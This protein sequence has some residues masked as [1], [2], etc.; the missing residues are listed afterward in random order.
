[1]KPIYE[2]ILTSKGID[3]SYADYLVAQAAL[4][5]NWGKSQSGKNNLSGIKLIAS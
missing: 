4:E 3:K 5:S 1:M 2:S